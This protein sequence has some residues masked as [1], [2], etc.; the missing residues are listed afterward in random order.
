MTRTGLPRSAN[1]LIVM[2]HRDIIFNTLTSNWRMQSQGIDATETKIFTN[3]TP[4]LVMTCG[5]FE[6]FHK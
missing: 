2:K 1:V 5:I 3:D 4:V 6:C